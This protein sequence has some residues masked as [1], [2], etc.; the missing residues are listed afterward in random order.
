MGNVFDQMAQEKPQSQNVTPAPS[1]PTAVV[2]PA[3]DQRASIGDTPVTMHGVSQDQLDAAT[4]PPSG[5]NAFD[6]MAAS[7]EKDSTSQETETSKPERPTRVGEMPRAGEVWKGVSEPIIPQGSI[8][9]AGHEYSESAPT[10]FS[11]EHP[12]VAAAA[13]GL[14]GTV[15]DTMEFAR[16]LT[17]P[18]S[19]A[20]FGLGELG[21]VPTA[22]GR[23]AKVGSRLAGVGFGAQGLVQSAEGVRDIAEKGVTPE[24]VNET[25]GGLGQAALSGAAELRG[26][27]AGNARIGLPE[28]KVPGQ[29]TT[30]RPTSE[31]TAGVE[32]PISALQQE[33]PS[34]TTRAAAKFATPE[35]AQ[36]F[37]NTVT[38]PAAQRQAISTLSQVA[39]DKI[40]AHEALVKGEAAPEKITGTQTPGEHLTPDDMWKGMQDSATQTWDKARKVSQQETEQWQRE[41][42]AAEA[43]HQQGVDHYN[44]LVEEHNADPANADNPMTPQVFDPSEIQMREKPKTY[45][46][47]R[48]ELDTAKDRLG[49]MNPTDVREKAKQT[50][51]PKAEKALDQWFKTHED[52]VSPSEYDSAKSLWADSER[53]K[54]MSLSLKR[55]LVTGKL[56]GNDI[57]GLE[58]TID[59]K[60]VRRRGQAGIGEFRRLVGPEAYDNLQKT[61]RLF[62]PL[63]KSDPKSIAIKSWGSYVAKHAIATVLAPAMFGLGY[64]G[65][66]GANLAVEMFMNHAM[67]DP[68]F[69]S[70]FTKIADA[71][72]TALA[73]GTQVPIELAGKFRDMLLGIAEKYKASRF[74]GEEGA[75]GYG[76]KKARSGPTPRPKNWPT[77]DN[78]ISKYGEAS[79]PAQTAFLL[80]DGRK[81]AMPAGSEHDRMLGGKPT[82]DFRTPYINETGNIRMRAYG[83]YGDR[84]FGL[85]LPK[86]GITEAQLNEIKKWGPQL[87]TGRVFL[88]QA[89]ANGKNVV[90]HNATNEQLEEAVRSIVPVKESP[91]GVSDAADEYNDSQN[92]P[93][94]DQSKVERDARRV[95]IADAYEKMKHNPSDPKVQEAYRALIDESKAQMKHLE[96]RGYKFDQTETDPYKTYEEM[97]DDVTKNKHLSVWTGGNPLASDHP[98]AGIDKETGWRNN[99]IMRGVHDVMG[100]VAGDNDFSETGEENAYNLHKQAFSAKAIP[101]LT[102]ETK[103]QTSWFFNNRGVREGGVPGDFPKQKAG[104][105]PEHLYGSDPVRNIVSLTNENG[106]ATFNPTRGDLS[107]TDAYAVPMYPELSR[108]VEGDKVTPAQVQKYMDIPEVKQALASDPNLSVGTWANG[109]KVYFD[110][111]STVSDRA[112]AIRLGKESG[113]KAITYLKNFEEIPLGGE[114]TGTALEPKTFAG[115]DFS[116]DKR[117]TDQAMKELV[118]GKITRAQLLSRA[119]ELKEAAKAKD[120][121]ASEITTRRPKA[122][123]ADLSNKPNQHANWDAIEQADRNNPSGETAL[124]KKR[125][126]Y[127]EKMA[128]TVAAYT[129]VAFTPEELANPDRV[130]SKFVTRV[131]QNLEWLYNQVPDDMKEQTKQWYDSA[132][133]VVK[134]K[135]A[136]YGFTPEQ[137]AGVVA[138]LSPQNPWD[139]NL[140]LANRTMDIY[141][142][143]Q[144]FPYSPEMESSAAELKK[145]PTQSKAFKGLLRDIAGK[146]LS[147]VTN[148]NKDVQAVQRAL[149]I[150]LYDEA[151]GNPVNDQ[152]APTGEVTG[153]S[154]DT[155][156]WIGL[157]HM[158][159]AVKILEDGSVDNIND[160]MGQGHKIRNFYNNLINPNSKAG[161]VTI[162]THATAAA[163]LQP[164]GGKDTEP[165]HTFGNTTKGTPGAPKDASTGLQGTYPLYA[166]AY[167]RVARKLGI[168]P[169]ELQSVTWEAIK[170]LMG[171]EKKTPEMKSQ[172]KEIWQDVQDGK[173][174]PEEARDKIKSTVGGFSKP[175]WMSDEEWERYGAEG[176]DTSFMGE[177]AQPERTLATVSGGSGAG[178]NPAPRRGITQN[179]AAGWIKPSG[180]FKEFDPDLSTHPDDAKRM[181]TTVKDLVKSGWVRKAGQGAY[182]GELTDKTAKAIDDDLIADWKD[183][184]IGAEYG[185]P[186]DNIVLTSPTGV[187][188]IIPKSLY[189]DVGFDIRK[190]VARVKRT[191]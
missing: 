105:L 149:W 52:V 191:K 31:M 127:K 106:G 133:R 121:S 70:T 128:R 30:I 139:N 175:A 76:V 185:V 19:I 44:K 69:G 151:H 49:P 174:T 62:D 95:Q 97:R 94:L 1:L 71:T 96:S 153:H 111:S 117:A 8:S 36:D 80:T 118:D 22:L 147:E 12:Y 129:G 107:G 190:A 130:L 115:M 138:A 67:F 160:V 134:A 85:S 40:A 109:G 103:G 132:N 141:R 178:E 17:S 27:K 173:L 39:T 172:V 3:L 158:S 15:S 60:A 168:L 45:D 35:K 86:G 176:E 126:G 4:I 125:M 32:A 66:E 93:A 79:D 156:S 113:Q 170:A 145:V 54:E 65:A 184:E 28:K 42:T 150:R 163:H 68:E 155:R 64:L 148:A 157:D 124:G 101:A 81:V 25:L 159:K 55:K 98:L 188:T 63:D 43:V 37:Q 61:A 20:T 88:E 57:R 51:V 41:R 56:N 122:V 144:N 11:V 186:V 24:T 2:S 84:Q 182:E 46:E 59:N 164:F 119:Q 120:L 82:D 146:K 48:A 114:G 47:L 33:N 89:D 53:F 165:T 137:G 152:Y 18:L 16:G 58:A 92:R 136:Q 162:D 179:A 91:K 177:G 154:P 90:L 181:G 110:L 116:A 187:D 83:V 143:R 34:L 112:Q 189:E 169:R 14:A 77:D 6:Q 108:T 123:G 29:R 74:S 167:Q 171:D 102:T 50:E 9:K 13:K 99:D 72:K 166:E 26:T 78:L 75:V 161:H 180:G 183:M 140:G 23:L 7:Q 142:N 73:N 10:K 21:E 5:G 100:H 87:R 104:V 38:K 135:A 131:S